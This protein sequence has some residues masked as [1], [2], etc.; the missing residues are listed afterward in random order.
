MFREAFRYLSEDPLRILTI[1][2]GAGGLV[3]WFDRWRYRTRVQV[4]D[5]GTST[6]QNRKHSLLSF[7]AENLGKLP[8]SIRSDVLVTGCGT[9]KERFKYTFCISSGDRNL[10]PNEPKQFS[11]QRPM[12]FEIVGLWYRKH[13]FRLTRGRKICVRFRNVKGSRDER[14][15][16]F[17]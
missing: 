17:G 2:G 7:E 16:R 6:S 10:P 13:V 9:K 5:I 12:T 11:A 8:T 3:Y 15:P 1:V 14:R 4:R